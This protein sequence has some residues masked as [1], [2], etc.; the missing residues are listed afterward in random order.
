MWFR[1][2]DGGGGGSRGLKDRFDEVTVHT[3][4]PDLFFNQVSRLDKQICLRLQSAFVERVLS[5]EARG[6]VLLEKGSWAAGDAEEQARREGE[7]PI[8]RDF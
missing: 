6:C 8:K 2:D 7:A 3:R 1:A 4:S 5:S